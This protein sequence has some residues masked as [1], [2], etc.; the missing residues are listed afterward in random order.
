MKI[1]KMFLSFFQSFDKFKGRRQ[2]FCSTKAFL[3]SFISFLFSDNI[4]YIE[5]NIK[6]II[7]LILRHQVFVI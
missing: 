6:Y 4:I 2:F 1:L 5:K 7:I 3:K